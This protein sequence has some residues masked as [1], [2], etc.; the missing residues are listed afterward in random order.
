M[1]NRAWTLFQRVTCM[2]FTVSGPILF[3]II[4]GI[5]GFISCTL[6]NP[7]LEF[8]IDNSYGFS[9]D[10]ESEYTIAGLEATTTFHKFDM[11]KPK[12]NGPRGALKIIGKVPLIVGWNKFHKRPLSWMFDRLKLCEYRCDYS[13]DRRNAS[14]ADVL[15]IHGGTLHSLPPKKKHQ[16]IVFF[17]RESPGREWKGFYRHWH[18][19]PMKF[20]D[21]TMTYHR[22]ANYWE[23][24]FTMDPI[25]SSEDPH[26]T[27]SEVDE[28]ISRKT[29]GSFF[30][31]SHCNAGS[32]R[33]QI[34]RQLNQYHE[35]SIFGKCDGASPCDFDCEQEVVDTTHFY[36][37]LENSVCTDYI[38]E[39]FYRFKRLIVPITFKREIVSGMVPDDAFIAVDDFCSLEELGK[40][41]NWLMANKKEYKRYFNWSKLYRNDYRMSDS[42][43]DMCEDLVFNR[44]KTTKYNNYRTIS[45]WMPRSQCSKRFGGK[46]LE[47][48][49]ANITEPSK[50]PLL[51]HYYSA[52]KKN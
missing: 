48:R 43:C 23:R 2:R 1:R 9:N 21:V 25:E 6:Y 51:I 18:Q 46:M 22:R 39:K 17:M 29:H 8:L 4:F 16:K 37:A 30:L 14:L 31:A 41:L 40:Y 12:N 38:T 42:I 33:D 49:C 27:D 10:I 35:V 3:L 11:S 19:V 36:L 15:I 34:V 7:L 32:K 24:Y 45:S 47:N 26:W 5:S 20:F 28:A 50:N 52:M 44:L 13:D